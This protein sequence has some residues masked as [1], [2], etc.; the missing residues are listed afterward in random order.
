MVAAA[1]AVRDCGALVGNG[2]LTSLATTLRDRAESRAGSSTRSLAPLVAEVRRTV[3]WL[4]IWRALTT[5]ARA[6]SAHESVSH[7]LGIAR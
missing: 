6:R 4:N 3:S 5:P 7:R 1:S 2:D